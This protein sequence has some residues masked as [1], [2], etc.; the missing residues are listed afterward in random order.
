[1]ALFSIELLSFFVSLCRTISW[2]D[3]RKIILLKEL[4]SPPKKAFYRLKFRNLQC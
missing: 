1:M 2:L 4:N 3:A